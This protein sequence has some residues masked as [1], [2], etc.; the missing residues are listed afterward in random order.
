MLLSLSISFHTFMWKCHWNSNCSCLDRILTKWE[1]VSF[2]S[3]SQWVFQSYKGR[4][5]VPPCPHVQ[6]HLVIARVST[7]RACVR[8][9]NSLTS[10]TTMSVHQVYPLTLRCGVKSTVF[11]RELFYITRNPAQLGDIQST[12][13]MHHL[14]QIQK[15]NKHFLR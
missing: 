13:W 9:T 15:D 11:R 7:S 8:D 3:L 4:P 1:Y 2:N 5:P 10:Q 14:L 12:S 6:L